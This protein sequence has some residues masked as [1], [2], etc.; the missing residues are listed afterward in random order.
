M[1]DA[2]K[3]ERQNPENFEDIVCDWP[4]KLLQISGSRSRPAGFKRVKG[5]GAG[6]EEEGR[7]NC[8]G[9]QVSDGEGRREGQGDPL[10][11]DQQEAGGQGGQEAVPPQG[12]GL[13]DSVL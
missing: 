6:G 10:G 4:L 12:Q 3:G 8:G 2:D 13:M 11:D 9:E 7:K 1:P 5:G